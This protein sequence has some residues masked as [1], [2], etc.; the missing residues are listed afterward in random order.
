MKNT[1]YIGIDGGGTK[2]N[3]ILFDNDKNSITS[4][5]MPTI[6]PAQTSFK[7]AV[8]ILTAAKEKLLINIKDCNYNLKVGAGLGGYGINTDYRKK[9]EDEF[10]MVFDDFKLYSD[11]Y[12]AMVG[13]L[14]GDD[15][16]LIIAGT[17]SIGFAKIG[18]NT[19]RCGGFGY[20]YGD[21]GS[22]YSIGRDIIST[23]LKEADGRNK[24]SK[25]SDL[26]PEYFNMNSVNDIATGDFTREHI[27]GLAAEASKYIYSSE[28]IKNIF[29]RAAREIT[30]HIRALS[31]KFEKNKRIKLSYIGG[32][33]KSDY[34]ME[35]IKEMNPDIDIVAPLFPPEK[36]SI[37][38]V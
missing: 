36:G 31:T 6:H 15:G 18:N 8:S 27:A 17:G 22:A 28:S 19:Y 23:A 33:F 10:S 20:R 4:V 35:L 30:L 16:I 5:L 38:Q 29:E 21:E 1:Y 37:L 13:A 24:K 25:I 12:I 7:E 32:V 9:L 11:A 26:V 14:G 3:F 34:I 2:T